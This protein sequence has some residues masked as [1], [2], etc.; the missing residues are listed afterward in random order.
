MG[1][2]DLSSEDIRKPVAWREKDMRIR[3]EVYVHCCFLNG[4]YCRW[5][6]QD[7]SVL[8][9][10]AGECDSFRKGQALKTSV[11]DE[12]RKE[13][14]IP[15][16]VGEIVPIPEELRKE[17]EEARKILAS[18]HIRSFS[19]TANIFT[20]ALV[21]QRDLYEDIVYCE[22]VF[23]HLETTTNTPILVPS[24]QFL[25]LLADKMNCPVS[26]FFSM[27]EENRKKA[28]YNLVGQYKKL[29]S[30]KEASYDFDADY[31]DEVTQKTYIRIT[32]EDLANGRDYREDNDNQQ[33]NLNSVD[34]YYEIVL[35]R[36]WV[37]E[38]NQNV[39][40]FSYA[41]NWGFYPKHFDF[42]Y[43]F[44]DC[45]IYTESEGEL[46]DLIEQIIEKESPTP[47]EDICI[48]TIK[49][50]DELSDE[51]SQSMGA[52]HISDPNQK[53][54]THR[55]ESVEEKD[56]R[57]KIIKETLTRHV[58]NDTRTIDLLDEFE[59][60]GE[61]NPFVYEMLEIPSA[62][63]LWKNQ[64]FLSLSLVV[65]RCKAS[66]C[67]GDITFT[68]FKQDKVAELK[69]YILKQI[70]DEVV[71]RYQGKRDLYYFDK[72]YRLRAQNSSNRTGYGWEWDWS[73]GV[74]DYI[75]GT[76]YGETTD[77]G[78]VGAYIM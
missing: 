44:T 66:E 32:L 41:Q 31:D 49:V 52:Y 17:R 69:E 14:K 54:E 64:D 38:Q 76:L 15:D 39:Y 18:L 13:G 45:E 35:E 9:S 8:Y 24:I 5:K 21:L 67:V 37:E 28:V 33:D 53:Q 29:V 47:F 51:S 65:K 26:M 55:I 70:T 36:I 2:E 34:P 11:I 42:N 77:Y 43:M 56:S 46:A 74:G 78:F 30:A 3:N 59:G 25:S 73:G 75:E 10:K 12:M 23:E 22:K 1:Q 57:G 16:G 61:G 27:T 60:I 58:F 50:S 48:E 63:Y 71:E 68:E 19:I 4:N 72:P 20:L 6:K 40:V 7:C 62:L